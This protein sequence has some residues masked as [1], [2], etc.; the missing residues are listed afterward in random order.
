M[1]PC[2]D[3]KLHHRMLISYIIVSTWAGT[4]SYLGVMYQI[5]S[6]FRTQVFLPQRLL[7]AVLPP[8]K[9]WQTDHVQWHTWILGGCVEEWHISKIKTAS[10]CWHYQ[11]QRWPWTTEQLSG[12][13]LAVMAI[14]LGFRKVSNSYTKEFAT[15]P[16]VHPM[17]RYVISRDK[18]YT[19][20]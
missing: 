20:W 7:L 4:W 5:L 14:F 3:S 1:K 2:I 6:L 10:K 19:S 9:A 15:P 18:F 8:V 17:S 12:Q 11:S 13:Y 16:H